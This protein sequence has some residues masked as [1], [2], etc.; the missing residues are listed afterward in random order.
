[1]L[2]H[3][4]WLFKAEHDFKSIRYLLPSSEEVKTALSAAQ[5]IL[6]FVKGE[7]T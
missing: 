6:N 3:E 7:I 4:M 5:R 1:M 2:P